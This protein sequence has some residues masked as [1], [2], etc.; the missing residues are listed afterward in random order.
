MQVQDIY[1]EAIVC[2]VEPDDKKTVVLCSYN[3]TFAKAKASATALLYRNKTLSLGYKLLGV[4]HEVHVYDAGLTHR[5][6]IVSV[7]EEGFSD[8]E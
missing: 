7:N 6:P 3:E 5:A 4:I 1:F 2:T 8:P